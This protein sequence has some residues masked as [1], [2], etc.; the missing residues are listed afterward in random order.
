MR[1][2]ILARLVLAALLIC[3]SS[4]HSYSQSN[5]GEYLYN[6]CKTVLD[7][8]NDKL[9]VEEQNKT[10]HIRGVC[11]GTALTLMGAQ[12]HGIVSDKFKYCIP[13]NVKP[14][15]IALMIVD[16]LKKNNQFLTYSIAVAS[17]LAVRNAWPC[18]NG[19]AG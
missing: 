14:N 3:T 15:F 4:G 16:F 1:N 19:R 5:T 17:V 7:D 10:A 18:Q 12:E 13:E 9:S 2:L 6:A 11:I 8:I